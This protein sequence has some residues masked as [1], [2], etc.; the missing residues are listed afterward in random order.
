MMSYVKRHPAVA[1]NPLPATDPQIW[2]V[3]WTKPQVEA[4]SHPNVIKCQIAMSKLYSCSEDVEVDVTSQA[5]YADR[6][7]VRYPG[8]AGNLPA[9]LDNGSIERWEDTEGCMTYRAIWEGRWEEYDAW[10]ID[11]RAEAVIDLYGG[12]GACSV[13]RSL[14]G[15]VNARVVVISKC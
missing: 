14:Q 15:E 13:F 11:H 6:F 9:H 5:M 12:P 8:Q 10:D 3:Y 7:R 4:R 1:G 2:R